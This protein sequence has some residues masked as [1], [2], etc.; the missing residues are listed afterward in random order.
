MK[1][2]TGIKAIPYKGKRQSGLWWK[3]AV[4][5]VLVGVLCF[6]V[7]EGLVLA[8]GR[9]HVAEGED[10]PEVMVIFGCKVEP[11][12]APSQLLQ[13]RLDTA[14]SYL[15]EHTEL[16]VVVSGGQGKD[17]P[18]SEAQCMY[19]YLT[20][21]GVDGTR[22]VQEDR[23]HN[24]WENVQYTL[25]LFHSGTVPSTGKVLLVSN[26]FHLARIELLWDRAWDGTLTVSTLAAPSSHF[27]SKVKM[28]LREPL[29]LAKS[30][31]FDR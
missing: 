10:A 30:F 8:G 29:A 9:T 23:S 16:T 12:G 20:A 7:L 22:I 25:E 18:M 11:W 15:E 24:T 1:Y 4:A 6:G 27:P 14:L 26:A 3:I 2:G 5:I 19:E 28:Y 21:N 31:L 13:D 17:E